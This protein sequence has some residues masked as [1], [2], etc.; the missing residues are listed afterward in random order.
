MVNSGRG[1][2]SGLANSNSN[3][4][5]TCAGTMRSIRSQHFQAALRLP[6]L[7]GAGAKPI[8]EGRDLGDAL[9]L[10]R[11]QRRLQRQ[12][13]GALLLEL[14]I[15][16]GVGADGPILDVQHPVD[17]GIEKFAIVRNHQQGAR[18]MP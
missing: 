1:V 2:F 12:L 17:D 16:A 11:L 9:H 13:L 3:G 14:R 10:P 18:E 4:L 15:I 7:G 5:S 8:H 6:R